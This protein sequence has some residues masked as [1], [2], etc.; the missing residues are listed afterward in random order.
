[1]K[2]GAGGGEQADEGKLQEG[3]TDSRPGFLN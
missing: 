3:N 2:R 1:M